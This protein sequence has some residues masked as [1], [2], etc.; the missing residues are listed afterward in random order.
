MSAEDRLIDAPHLWAAGRREGA[1]LSIM[2]AVA[3]SARRSHPDLKDREAFVTFLKSQHSWTISVEFRG[4]S[5]TWTP[6]LIGGFATSLYTKP[7]SRSTFAW[8]TVSA[9]S[10]AEPADRLNT[11]SS[12]LRTR[13]PISPLQLGR[14]REGQ[15]PDHCPWVQ[16]RALPRSVRLIPADHL[17][18]R[19]RRIRGRDVRG[20]YP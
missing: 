2:V 8:T 15:G 17:P 4:S 14:D 18:G 7:G 13:V 5:G 1:L 6:R 10:K 3:V 12:P 19:G 20:L 9:G 11:R 16:G